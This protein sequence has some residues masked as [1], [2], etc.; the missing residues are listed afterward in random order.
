MDN[1]L[2]KIHV[3]NFASDGYEP[4]RR[5]NTKTAYKKGGDIVHEY[6]IHDI[7]REFAEKNKLILQQKR[8]CGYWLWKPYFIYK[9]LLS[10]DE[11]D[12]IVYSDSGM[13]YRRD[14]KQYIKQL[15]RKDISFITCIT[16]FIEKAYTKRDVFIELNCDTEKYTDS[17]QKAGGA[18]FIKN[19]TVN[20]KVVKEWLDNAQNYHWI[21]DEA[22]EFPNYEEFVDHRH[23]QSLFSLLSKKHNIA[24]DKYLFLDM[25]VPFKKNAVLVLHHSKCGNFITAY[26]ATLKRV[27]ILA[28]GICRRKQ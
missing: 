25:A 15:E 20:Q 28:Y 26:M 10:A 24:Y 5:L 12:W 8:G 16:K 9:V 3:I 18:M 1:E 17:K 6:T 22:S 13:Y 2:G 23:D 27:L 11:N 19:T 7:D 4:A 14:M 21:T